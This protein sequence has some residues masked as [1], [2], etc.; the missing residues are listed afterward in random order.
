MFRNL[1]RHGRKRE[2][3]YVNELFKQL[4]AD[5]VLAASPDV[6][7]VEYS[8]G[9]IDVHDHELPGIQELERKVQFVLRMTGLL[10]C[11]LRSGLK[12][13]GYIIALK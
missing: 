2:A 9:S 6:L 10:H 13:T 1:G 12:R 7:G 8:D 11:V 5:V 4:I 3:W